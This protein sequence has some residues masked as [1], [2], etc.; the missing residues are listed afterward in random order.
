MW[1]NKVELIFLIYITCVFSI[2]DETELKVDYY[3]ALI[4]N[5]IKQAKNYEVRKNNSDFYKQNNESENNQNA[6]LYDYG[7][8]DFIVVGAGTSGSVVASRLSENRNW[9]ILLLEAGDWDDDLTAI[10]YIQNIFSLTDKSWGYFTTPQKNACLGYEENRCVY[11]QGKVIGGSGSINGL[12]YSRGNIGD[13][14]TWGSL[15]NPGWKFNDVLP[16]F[17]KL[18]NFES[19]KINSQ[20]RGFAGPL[21]V[22]YLKFAQNFSAVTDAYSEIGV[23]VTEDYNAERQLGVSL[24]QR[25]IAFGRRASGATAYSKPSS[26]RYNL[27]ITLKALVTKILISQYS[28][29]AFGVHF[30]KNGRN[31]IA[32]A[33]EEIILSS[34]AINSPQ[35]LQL[36]GIGPKEEL[37]KHNIP[38]IVNSPVGKQ[39]KEHFA[40]SIHFKTDGGAKNSSLREVITQYLS[41]K[42]I[43]TSLGNS[44]SFSYHKTKN[45]PSESNLEIVFY[46]PSPLC[47]SIPTL[48]NPKKET[49]EFFKNLDNCNNVNIVVYLLHPK[50]S[51]TLRLQSN[52]AIDFPLIDI[53]MFND[54]SDLED[55]YEG[56]QIVEKLSKT[57]LAKE[58][59]WKLIRFDYCSRENNNKDYW[60]CVLKQ[61]ATP[62]LHP[63]SSAKMGSKRDPLAVVDQRLRVYGV[64]RL[65]VADCSVM[66]TP[67]SGHNNAAAFLIGE[68][69]ADFIKQD[70][71]FHT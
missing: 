44:V 52:R 19:D 29:T 69:A 57:R 63:A 37:A 47:L 41:G 45:S 67:I 65:R 46:L 62:G 16:Y 64:N 34:S 51:G 71:H 11:A 10:P 36:S 30:V 20:Y 5:A 31:Y 22:A 35:I 21:N 56:I 39:L 18:E 59:G 43:L 14:N 54:Q 33:K 61:L 50:S 3:E 32:K 17:K 7:T 28:K 49:L 6:D 8:F 27:N 66:P 48:S 53:G 2:K 13:Y 68:R 26:L 9:R 42:G 38:L 12:G 58:N 70:H 55:L 15:G 23:P 40:I 4:E 24:M 1:N 60:F 25:N